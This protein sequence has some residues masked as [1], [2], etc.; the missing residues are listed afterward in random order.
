MNIFVTNLD[1]VKS[2][3]ALDDKRVIKMV[4]ESTQMLCTS[5]NEMGGITPYKSSHKNHPCSVW[6]RQ[7]QSNFK[8][9]LRHALALASQYRFRYGKTHKC[10]AILQDIDNSRACHLL[11]DG[12]MSEFVNCA[13]N[14]SKGVCFKHVSDVTDAYRQYLNLR[15]T[16]D[17]YKPTWTGVGMPVWADLR[18][19]GISQQKNH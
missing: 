2:A 7:N 13:A 17:V 11:P 12:N 3:I 19:Y 8:W 4:L 1:C 14:V 15:W 5:V 9:L 18:I 10:N 6:A 16:T